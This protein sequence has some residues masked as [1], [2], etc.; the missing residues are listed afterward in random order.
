MDGASIQSDVLSI[1]NL[2]PRTTPSG[3]NSPTVARRMSTAAEL[4]QAVSVAPE[5]IAR[6]RSRT[7]YPRVSILIP[8]YNAQ[9][10]LVSAVESMLRQSFTDF[11]CIVV[12]DGSTDRTSSQLAGLASRDGRVRPLH[13]PHGGI[14]E[15]LNAGIRAARGELIARMDAD[16]ISL[17]Q[18]L[19]EQVRFMDE[20]P[21]VVAMG[22]KVLLVDPH[23]SPL[24]EIDV[25]TAH[26]DIETEL[27]RGNGWALFHPTALIRK[28]AMLR[29]GGYRP[30]YQ[31][32][33]DIDLFLRLA[34]VG[35]LANCDVP[36]LR[37]RQHF[38]SVNHTKV[39]LQARRVER[40]LADAHQRRRKHLSP[41]WRF[42][43]TQPLPRYEQLR[44][45]GRRAIVNRNYKVAR[46]HAIK[47][48]AA[49]PTKYEAWSLMLHALIGR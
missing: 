43:P 28:D 24:W 1:L 2:T 17:P 9:R 42:V 5:T 23:D 20:Q 3:A 29:V 40:L 32:S 14:V 6:G 31:W 19:A 22:S 38:S 48:L 37:Y 26:A 45:W 39:E 44:A 36:L 12:D 35:K 49:S 47:A 30:E 8:A 21:N 4:A 13:V 34:E 7:E 15:A 18:R 11:E 16:D 46:K 33:E 25:K 27:L 10:Y 41:D